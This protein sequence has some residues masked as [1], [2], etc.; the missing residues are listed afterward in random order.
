MDIGQDDE[1]ASDE[2]LGRPDIMNRIPGTSQFGDW[3]YVPI[4]VKS[5]HELQKYQKLQLAFYAYL[6]SETQ[7]SAVRLAAI[8]NADKIQIPFEVSTVMSEMQDIVATLRA[9]R[10]GKKPD[11]VLRKGCFDT[12]LWGELCKKDAE[13]TD[14]IALLYNVD[15]RKLAAL[16]GLGVRTVAEAA[17]IDPEALDH[18]AKGL[19]EHGLDVIKLQA[20]SL[21]RGLVL[22]REPVV[23]QP[24]GLEIHFDIESDPPND[25][26][27]LYGI[28]IRHPDGDE[29]LP[30]VAHGGTPAAERRMWQEFLEWIGTLPD[31]YTVYHFA[32][33]ER[34]RLSVLENRYGRDARLDKFRANLVDLKDSLRHT[35]VFP[36]YFYG[37]KYICKFL[38]FKW[39][40]S[41]KSGGASVDAFEQYVKTGDESILDDII[42]YNEDDV[43]ATAFLRDWLTKYARQINSYEPP[44]PWSV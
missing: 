42:L 7:G 34:S 31:T 15:V 40:S 26:D 28:L 43:R 23:V 25:L 35:M 11:A 17:E 9:V 39:R 24:H 44:Y 41:V 18:A 3:A 14:D 20:Q 38:G 13:S 6:L 19:T 32:P 29:Y 37:L 36:L 2:L 12:G 21:K 22:V 16:R 5:S 4:D 8:V 27:Y 33:Y 30:F 1:P 10:D